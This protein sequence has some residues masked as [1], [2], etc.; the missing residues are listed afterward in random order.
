MKLL[1]IM[2]VIVPLF[3][4]AT[5]PSIQKVSWGKPDR[6]PA[7]P[8]DWAECMKDDRSNGYFGVCMHSKGYKQFYFDADGKEIPEHLLK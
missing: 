6:S 1:A 7:S 3:G 5:V 2:S 8:K 4:C